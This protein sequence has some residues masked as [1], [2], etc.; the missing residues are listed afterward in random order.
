MG[1]KVKNNSLKTGPNR[2][3]EPVNRLNRTVLME[4]GGSP[5]IFF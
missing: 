5:I 4:P 2:P 3:V 1:V